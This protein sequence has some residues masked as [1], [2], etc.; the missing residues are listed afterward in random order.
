[1]TCHLTLYHYIKNHNKEHPFAPIMDIVDEC[2]LVMSSTSVRISYQ[3]HINNM[4]CEVC[5]AERIRQR[6]FTSDCDIL[7]CM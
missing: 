6:L 7:F 5:E 1:M 2:E 4:K 3:C